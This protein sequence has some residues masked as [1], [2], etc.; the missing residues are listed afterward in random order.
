LEEKERK[1]EDG[2]SDS[3]VIGGSESLNEC[4][5]VF[6]KVFIEGVRELY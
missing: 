2:R 3:K 4:T 5:A 1:E 6:H